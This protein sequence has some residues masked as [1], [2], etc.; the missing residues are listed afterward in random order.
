MQQSDYKRE[1]ELKIKELEDISMGVTSAKNILIW[2][3]EMK[4]SIE[5][6]ENEEYASIV[7]DLLK[8]VGFKENTTPSEELDCL[9][10]LLSKKEDS[11][12]EIYG[13]LILSLIMTSL[14]NR[15]RISVEYK[16]LIEM[17][18]EKYNKDIIMPDMMNKISRHIGENIT[19]IVLLNGKPK[20][21]TGILKEVDPYRT[22]TIDDERYPF[23]GYH[24]GMIKI[25][26]E[27]GKVLY[28]N[29]YLSTDNNLDDFSMI[30]K[31][32]EELFGDRYK[33]T[34]NKIY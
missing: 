31:M 10:K 8:R 12:Y 24:V 34:L 23:I 21:L 17:Y 33:E 29:S 3:Y 14:K 19:F 1:L 26:S 16:Q 4:D 6:F 22:V 2:F 32:N 9:N 27:F 7:F 30:E 11:S 5:L 28:N 13:S 18:N 20:I 15:E 25:V